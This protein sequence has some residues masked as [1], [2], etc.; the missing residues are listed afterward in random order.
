MTIYGSPKLG[1]TGRYPNGKL[2]PT[3]EG[4]LQLAIAPIGGVVRME[5]AK[6][7][8]WMGMYPS[9][10]RAMAQALLLAADE[11]ELQ[12]AKPLMETPQ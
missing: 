2:D 12:A 6:P 7:V 3:D 8:A 10:A 5:F 1:G 9:N 4:E 11:A